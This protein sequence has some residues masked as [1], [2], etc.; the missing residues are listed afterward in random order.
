MDSDGYL[1]NVVF[2]EFED[3]R[4]ILQLKMGL[5]R[6]TSIKYVQTPVEDIAE[7]LKRTDLKA[8]DRV[9]FLHA[10]YLLVTH[11]SMIYSILGRDR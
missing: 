3:L 5:Q 7:A 10:Y 4:Y 9:R 8:E 6:N 1:V 2:L 11:N